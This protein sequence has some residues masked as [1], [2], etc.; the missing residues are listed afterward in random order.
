MSNPIETTKEELAKVKATNT[1]IDIESIFDIVKN[2]PTNNSPTVRS[3]RS[4][5]SPVNTLEIVRQKLSETRKIKDEQGI[6]QTVPA[7]S[8]EDKV[9]IIFSLLAERGLN[10]LDNL[11]KILEKDGYRYNQMGDGMMEEGSNKLIENINDTFSK[12]TDVLKEIAEMQ[13]K[14]SKLELDKE[15][16][17]IQDYKAKLKEKE[18]QIKEKALMKHNPT[19]GNTNIIAVASQSELIA[20]MKSQQSQP[21]VE[22]EAELLDE[23]E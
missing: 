20:L 11:E 3:K 14:K 19:G 13:F 23:K 17:R 15:N 6:E 7:Y 21:V 1:N 5:H 8:E 2:T 12:T 22:K 10:L 16:L 4:D 9:K 18:L